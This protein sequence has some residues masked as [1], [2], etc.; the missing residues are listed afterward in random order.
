VRFLPDRISRK[1]A[2]ILADEKIMLSIQKSLREIAKGKSIH[3]SQ[4]LGVK[5][6]ER[7]H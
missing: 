5:Y 2:E 4:L 1:T 6:K 3:T 7:N